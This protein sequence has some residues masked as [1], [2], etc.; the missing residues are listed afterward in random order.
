MTLGRTSSIG[1]IATLIFAEPCAAQDTL[2]LAV[3]QQGAFPT[4]FSEL[5]STAGFFKK[6]N[7]NL[8]I[9]YTQGG[10]ET[11]QPVISGSVDIGIGIGTSA[12]LGAYSKGAPIRIIGGA[13]TGAGDLVWVVKSDSPLKKITDIDGQT[14]AYSSSGSSTQLVA[15]ALVEQYKVNARLIATGS[16]L[17]TMTATISGQVDVGWT[18]PPLM[19]EPSVKDKIRVL[20]TGDDAAKYAQQTIRVIATN[21]NA[22]KTK[23]DQIARFMSAYREVMNWVYS[24]DPAAIRALAKQF[25]QTEEVTLATRD[26]VYKKPSV[27]PDRISDM[28]G[29]MKDA[30]EYK[31]LAAPLDGKQLNELIVR[32]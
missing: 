32:K 24:G 5:G 21:A 15:K 14:F 16:Y 23:G 19:F 28:E 9:V 30:V 1:V 17:T 18:S 6:H 20:V 3:G 11:L 22:L 7:L 27:D 29:A 12:V 26:Q 8:D 2:K 4:S 31:F 25:S 10:G 13:T